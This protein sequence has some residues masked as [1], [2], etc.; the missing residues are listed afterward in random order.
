MRISPCA[1][2]GPRKC[3]IYQIGAPGPASQVPPMTM[4]GWALSLHYVITATHHDSLD[5]SM[6]RL[7]HLN[8]TTRIRLVAT[9]AF[10]HYYN[11]FYNR[12]IHYSWPWLPIDTLDC[13]RETSDCARSLKSQ[14]RHLPTFNDTNLQ[15]LSAVTIPPYS[16]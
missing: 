1:A 11:F 4:Q 12:Y 7:L 6:W 10:I 14:A 16:R 8:F 5:T 2:S 9:H 13:G 3:L 15:L